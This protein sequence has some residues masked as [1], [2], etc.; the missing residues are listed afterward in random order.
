MSGLTW[1]EAESIA[2]AISKA[3]HSEFCSG[4]RRGMTG[5]LRAESGKLRSKMLAPVTVFALKVNQDAT[6]IE[7]DD[8]QT[9]LAAGWSEQT[10]EDVVALV[11]IQKLYNTIATGLGFKG[12]PDAAF[13]EIGKDTVNKGGY[14]ASF[15]GFIEHSAP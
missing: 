11:A 9:V 6:S 10:V 3:N 8:I 2:A 14:V 13:T 12:L 1:L 5:A 15:Q 4:I 7:P